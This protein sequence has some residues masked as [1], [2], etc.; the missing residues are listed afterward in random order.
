MH[1]FEDLALLEADLETHVAAELRE[2]SRDVLGRLAAGRAVD[3][4]HHV[5]V[6]LHDGLRD[7]EDVD[8]RLREIGAGLG[9]DAD[10]VF[11]NNCNNGFFHLI[12]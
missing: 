10:R 8:L 12:S 5:E 9:E 1:A 4:H 2:S 11:S 3:D 6:V 7:V